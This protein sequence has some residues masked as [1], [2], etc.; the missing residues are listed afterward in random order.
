MKPPYRFFPSIF[1]SFPFILISLIAKKPDRP[2]ESID[3]SVYKT[4][5]FPKDL[6]KKL[7]FKPGLSKDQFKAFAE[8]IETS[9]ISFDMVPIKGGVFSMGSSVDDEGRGE[10]ELTERKVKVSDFWMGKHELT[11]DHK[12]GRRPSFRCAK[13]FFL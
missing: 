8:K 12:V 5:L 9:D 13:S 1:L 2:V 10:S 7:G 3:G 6:Y 11:K 4:G